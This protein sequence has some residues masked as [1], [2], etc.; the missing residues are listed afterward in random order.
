MNNNIPG[1]TIEESKVEFNRRVEFFNTPCIRTTVF[2]G[3]GLVSSICLAWGYLKKD[4]GRGLK[5]F[6]GL[7]FGLTGVTWVLCRVYWSKNMRDKEL[8][9]ATVMEQNIALENIRR[10]KIRQVKLEEEQINA[11]LKEKF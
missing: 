8:Y 1:I 3:T 10:E 7:W 4:Y 11:K 9:Q 6:P 2:L 5:L